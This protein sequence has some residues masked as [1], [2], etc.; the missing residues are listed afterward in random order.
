MSQCN[1]YTGGQRHGFY[2][3]ESCPQ[4]STKCS[5]VWELNERE[6]KDLAMWLM[7][8]ST[9]KARVMID[10][11]GLKVKLDGS[12]PAVWSRGLGTWIV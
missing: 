9:S 10:S 6:C 8:S 1:Q 7:D 3:G 5:E 4:C 12:V 2:I 11:E